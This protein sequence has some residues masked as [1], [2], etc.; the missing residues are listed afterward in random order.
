MVKRIIPFI[1]T[2]RKIRFTSKITIRSVTV[3]YFNQL[4]KK[5]ELIL[6]EN[7]LEAGPVLGPVLADASFKTVSDPTNTRTKLL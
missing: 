2:L 3:G 5:R 6:P 7:L 4:V 1:Q